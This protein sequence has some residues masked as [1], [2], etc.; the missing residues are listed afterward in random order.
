MQP[1]ESGTVA[2]LAEKPSVARD[3]AR[4][5]GA[6]KRGKGYLQGNGYVVT[7]AIGHLVS[8]AEPHQI[9]PQWRQWRLEALPI[10]PEH[11]PLVVYERSKEQFEVVEKI[12]MSPR[13]SRIVC[14]TDAG[15]EGELIFRYIYEATKSD[16]PFSRLWISSLTPDAIRKGFSSLRPG[17]DYDRLADAA[18]GRSRADWLVGMNLSRAYSIVYN[19]E[20]SVGRV[21]T[22]TLAM[23]VDRELALRRFVPEDYLQVVATFQANQASYDGTWFRP[24]TKQSEEKD[25]SANNRL[26]ADG[27]EADQI[28]ARARTG[29]ATIESLKSETVR[30]QPPLLYDLTELQRHANRLYGFSAQKT[31][32]LAQALYEQHKLISYP[33]TDSRH[34]STDIA[35]TL[36]RITA[37]ISGPYRQQLAPGTGERPLGKRYVDDNKVSDHHAIIPTTVALQPGRLSDEESKI[38]DLVCRRLLMLW[39]DD[40]QQE[41]TTVITAIRSEK[42]SIVDRYRTTGT[43]VRQTGW[44]ILDV[45]GEVR[46]E[47]KKD[48]EQK[49]IDQAL[50]ATLAQ[51]QAQTVTKVEAV[52]KKTRPP[53]RFTD[54]TILT[55]MQTAGRTLDEKELSDAMKETGLGTPATRA[56]II[57][58]LLKRGY[59]TRT[60]KSLEAT[61]KGIHLIEVVHPEVKSPAMTGQWEAFLNRIQ[62]GEAQLDPFIERISEY[63]RSV[64]GR[65]SQTTPVARTVPP[66]RAQAETTVASEA[67]V[68]KTIA[69]D[70][71]LGQLLQSVFG[72]SSFRPNQEAVC[73]AVTAGEDALLVM[74][75][76]SGKSLCY[77]LPGLARGGTTLV[78]SPLIALMDD[79]VRKLK[80]LGLSAEC[81][82]SGRDRES[83]RQACVEYMKGSLQFLFI[84]PERLR[85]PGFPE[86]LAKRKPSLVAIDEA[87][88]ISQWGHDFRPDYRMLGQYLPTLRPAPALAL[89]ATAT[90]LVQKDIAAQLGLSTV[91]HFIH[92]FRRENIGIEI[93]EALPSQRAALARTILLEAGNRPAIVYTPTRKQA[94]AL[95]AT[96]SRE[97]CVAGY[98]AGLDAQRRRRVQEEFMGGKLDVMVATTAFGMGIDKADV[99]TVIHTAFPGSLEGYYQEIG[100]AGRDGKPSRAVL[101]YSYADRHTHDFFFGRDYPPVTL[102]DRIF[103]KLVAEPQA[104][105][106]VRKLAAMEEDIF[107][108]ALEKLWIHKGAVVDYAENVCR[109]VESWRASYTMQAE[110]KQGQLEE[111]IR[112]AESHHCRMTSLVHHFGDT[113]DGGS[114]CGICDFCAPANCVAQRFRGATHAERIACDRV[115]KKLRGLPGRSTG[116]LH[117]ELFPENEMSRDDF[118]EVLGAMARAELLAFADAVFEKQGKRI[119]YRTVSIL[120]AGLNIDEGQRAAFV[121][122][123]AVAAVASSKRGKKGA[124]V[125]APRQGKPSEP[126]SVEA[127]PPERQA[128]LELALRAWRLTEAKRRKMPAFRI[129]GDRT[130]RNIASTCPKSDSA[131]LAVPGIGMGTVEKYGAQ[132]YHLVATAE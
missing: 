86:M 54:A 64:V 31:L 75:T 120:P 20:L 39:H 55:A 81:I 53:Q 76:G 35:E 4:V 106:K 23:I 45:G 101:M 51:G 84:A 13:V 132:I 59:V 28:I 89:T 99:R 12:L 83:S 47:L 56:A 17:S 42:E 130:L 29:R 78:I 10:L 57:E 19:E 44:K 90:P 40:H 126:A 21:Q 119:P 36:P 16:K 95:S 6:E 103:D 123:D 85:V 116:K 49:P 121:M 26:P 48:S 114:G 107:D 72:F 131:L 37:A 108:K 74:P 125:A 50:P 5:L 118:E 66:L 92:G 15:R 18:S 128:R 115:L 27:Q 34:L 7:W 43:V 110:Q 58:V 3:I 33:R 65:V 105:E 127:P 71:T 82:H 111:I 102:L 8:L 91:K 122:R 96:W 67:P 88:C 109:G 41:V 98:H 129:F 69:G 9:N 62:Q 100:R 63:V 87:H 79:Q 25:P 124:P 94:E 52:K 2:V 73:Q 80:D 93:V 70:A 32:D 61:D 46:R 104:K 97:F 113:S 30:M 117:A 22:P 38:Y 112:F 77:Q 11:W 24:Y 60:G 68:R 1:S 14:A